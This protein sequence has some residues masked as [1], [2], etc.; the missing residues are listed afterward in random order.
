MH[1]KLMNDELNYERSRTCVRS[2]RDWLGCV[3]PDKSLKC[4]G[5]R[6]FSR[7]FEHADSKYGVYFY[8]SDVRKPARISFQN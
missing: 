6:T 2:V 1:G 3:N 8:V 4:F 7:A 5:F